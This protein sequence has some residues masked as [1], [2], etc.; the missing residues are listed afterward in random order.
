[1]DTQTDN[2][3]TLDRALD[4]ASSTNLHPGNPSNNGL[5][6]MTGRNNDLS[7]MTGR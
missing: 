5:S 7:G 2:I 6:G 1:M 3:G 4:P